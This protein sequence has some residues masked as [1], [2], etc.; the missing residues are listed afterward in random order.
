MKC[1]FLLILLLSAILTSTAQTAQEYTITSKI[2][3]FD[4]EKF[5]LTIWNGTSETIRK[6]GTVKDGQIYFKDTTS[7][8]L[9]I[10]VELSTE[11]MYKRSGNGY[12]P[13]K[14]QH[15][16]LVALPG[17]TVHLTGHLSDFS[18]VYPSGDKEND[19]IKA[20]NSIYHPLINE[21]ANISLKLGDRSLPE[22]EIVK[23]RAQQ[24]ELNK[25]ANDFMVG[26]LQKNANSIAGL[27]YLNDMLLR[28]V[29]S[30]EMAED[31]LPTIK[32]PYRSTSYFKTLENRVAG[33]KFDVGRPIFKIASSNT[34]DG[35]EF[36]IDNWKGKFYLIDFWGSWCGPCMAD[37]PD[38][39]KLKGEFPNDLE[40]LGIAQDKDEPWRR[41]I[42]SNDLNWAHILNGTGDND[43][44]SRLNVTGFPTKILVDP[45]G[46]IVYRS[47]GGG[48]S[49]FQK[50]GEIMKAWGN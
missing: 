39:K 2:K 27:Y 23:L 19:V 4:E 3:D 13:V 37:I 31:L 50:M 48:V 15:I 26:F 22:E 10:R 28:K 24:A 9:I 46:K 5:G 29:V 34:L 18:E 16:W 7:V 20:L 12:M 38:L 49:S 43:F 36:S 11:R 35:K 1:K 8:P 6:Q 41:A 14:S 40:I 17:K 25:K 44:V 42:K 21:S 32:T 47:S 33:S 45:N 30:I